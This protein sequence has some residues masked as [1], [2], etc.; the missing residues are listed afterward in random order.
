MAEFVLIRAL[1]DREAIY[2]IHAAHY[3]CHVGERV[4]TITGPGDIAGAV[5]N[6]NEFFGTFAPELKVCG[7]VEQ[8]LNKERKK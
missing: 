6:I 5:K 7:C 4:M 8:M 2:T 3:R 1:V